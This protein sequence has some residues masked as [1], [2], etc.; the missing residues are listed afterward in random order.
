MLHRLCLLAV[1]TLV[2]W[3]CAA[4]RGTAP[5][6]GRHPIDAQRFHRFHP[7]LITVDGLTG[8]HARLVSMRDP[9]G[10]H[11]ISV[12]LADKPLRRGLV[13]TAPAGG[14]D[15]SAFAAVAIDV[16]NTGRIPLRLTGR[17][18]DLAADPVLH[19]GLSTGE[20]T[21]APG[22]TASIR[23]ALPRDDAFTGAVPQLP[24]MKAQ[25]HA[26]Y[27]RLDPSRIATIEVFAIE[28]EAGASFL[29]ATIAGVGTADHQRQDFLPL[30]DRF[31]QYRHDTWPG[32]IA[33]DA[34]LAATAAR[35]AAE[36][37]ALPPPPERT[38][39]GGWAGGPQL[40]ATGFFRTER[41][42][43]RWWLV[44]PEGRLFWSM[45]LCCVHMGDHTQV[46]G[47]ESFFADLPAADSETGRAS[48][49]RTK[50]GVVSWSARTAN[51]L[52]QFGNEWKPRSLEQ[53]LLRLERWG[54]NTL[55]A[56]S[57]GEV[58]R[59]GRVPYM[60]HINV[61]QPLL[62]PGNQALRKLLDPFDPQF[63]AN[64]RRAMAAEAV[65][66]KDPWCL[67]YFVNNEQSWGGELAE[68]GGFEL[69]PRLLL[70]AAPESAAKQA[71]VADLRTAHGD[72]AALNAAWGTSLASWE[73]LLANRE[74]VRPVAA[75]AA[76]D[77]RRFYALLADTFYRVCREEI[78]AAAPNHL[79]CGDRLCWSNR[80]VLEAAARHCD[81]VSMNVYEG[82]VAEDVHFE[83]YSLARL[84][85]P[86]LIT[87]FSFGACD[88]GLFKGNLA[89][90]EAQA[91]RGPAL[92]AYLR[93]AASHPDVVGAH[94][95]QYTDQ[96]LTGRAN[97]GENYHFGLVD[98]ANQP[99]QDLVTALRAFSQQLYP[100]RQQ[101]V[102]R[103]LPE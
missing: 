69:V 17:V 39:F 24:G 58:K 7:D 43:G 70:S 60:G 91:A 88:R 14:W 15:L 31:G 47:R 26:R 78:R 80:L 10:R 56:W 46:T 86:I 28:P 18:R 77:L 103:P 6:D 1:S 16:V 3:S 74:P 59:A 22:A 54:I 55:G 30:V 98:V 100:L 61:S 2:L 19:H 38:R 71:L 102:V 27:R 21:L 50:D 95:F 34:A 44:D 32:K 83:G 51:L 42:D 35:A 94:W 67:G 68:K 41:V 76:A 82:S 9:A 33:D 97:D 87:E 64:F 81:V 96:P 49:R 48:L 29:V 65:S 20:A 13:C 63:R 25:P 11:G 8:E 45:G 90:V 40:T 36:L 72:I 101:A 66:A 85:K 62:L 23:V 73:A 99:D 4:P 12:E 92:S 84:D 79:F 53:T 75:G 89:E 52:R 37:S 93:G 57:A 5:A